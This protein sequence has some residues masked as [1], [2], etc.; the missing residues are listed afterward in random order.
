MT[1]VERT[2]GAPLGAYTASLGR[3][4]I[5]CFRCSADASSC[6]SRD[7]A[8]HYSSRTPIG[9]N[10]GQATAG[11]ETRRGG[12]GDRGP[13]VEAKMQAQVI[14]TSQINL[15]GGRGRVAR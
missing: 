14:A 8:R 12:G 2:A 5:S 1:V 6:R 15:F 10:D 13:L 7:S 11:V 9:E 3:R 4:S